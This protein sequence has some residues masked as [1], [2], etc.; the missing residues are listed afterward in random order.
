MIHSTLGGGK[1]KKKKS[2]SKAPVVR[3]L[4]SDCIPGV[5]MYDPR[6]RE[7]SVND[8]DDVSRTNQHVFNDARTTPLCIAVNLPELQSEPLELPVESCP[9]TIVK[10]AT[11]EIL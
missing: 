1:Q 5:Y 2:S 3:D 6:T 4:V 8:T 9:P 11:F 7:R 10:V